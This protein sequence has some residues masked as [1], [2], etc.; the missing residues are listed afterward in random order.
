MKENITHITRQID[1]VLFLTLNGDGYCG[2]NPR[3][4]FETICIMLGVVRDIFPE[5]ANK[6]KALGGFNYDLS[7]VPIDRTR[8][9]IE[10]R[11]GGGGQN[12]VFLAR[13]RDN[14]RESL[15]L[16]FDHIR[17]RD[18]IGLTDLA[19]QI[20]QEC[21]YV[22]QAF[23]DVHDL[24]LP[25]SYFICENPIRQEPCVVTIQPYLNH[26][27]DYKDISFKEWEALFEERPYLKDQLVAI[28]DDLF[29]WERDDIVP[30]VVGRDNLVVNSRGL[31]FIDSFPSKPDGRWA[32]G[33]R[34][35]YGEALSYIDKIASL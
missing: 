8:Y 28:K 20:K 18:A 31:I 25:E 19:F 14:G 4:K 2:E 34:R 32:K 21:G 26:F 22:R 12:D 23:A 24:F 30:D 9:Y 7:R 29:K 35:E 13:S 3:G 1:R 27:T 11:I 5:L 10:S 6:V 16:K 33:Y 17:G 15:V